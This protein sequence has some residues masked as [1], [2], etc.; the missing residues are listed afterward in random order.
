MSDLATLELKHRSWSAQ[1][2]LRAAGERTASVSEALIKAQCP[3]D[4]ELTLIDEQPFEKALQACYRAGLE[5]GRDWTIMI[6]ADLMLLRGA[7]EGLL[8]AAA[9]QTSSHVQL[10][11]RIF[12]KITGVYRSAGPRIYRTDLLEQALH[13]IPASGQAIRPEYETLQA[14]E[15]LGHPSRFV[16]DVFA[17]HD[18]EQFYCDLYRKAFVHARKHAWLVGSMLERCR[19]NLADDPDFLVMLKGLWDGL[20]MSDEVSIDRRLFID[21]GEMALSEL[22]L[23]EKEPL[24]TEIFMRNFECFVADATQN[25]ELPPMA[26]YD[27]PQEPVP[28]GLRGS[29]V[30]RV[31]KRGLLGGSVASFGALLCKMGRALDS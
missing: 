9:E 1:L 21:K 23:T 22:G 24:N 2:V 29:V 7:I 5:A 31:R 4:V 3:S 12:D 30:H 26:I 27:K 18:F 20:T 10:Q 13:L 17:L 8:R 16:P 25:Y 15:R 11:G 19:D 6:D 14:M 28:S